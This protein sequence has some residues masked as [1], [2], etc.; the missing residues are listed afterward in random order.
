MFIVCFILGAW[1]IVSCVIMCLCAPTI[2]YA[3]TVC[4]GYDRYFAYMRCFFFAFIGRRRCRRRHR[5]TFK[6]RSKGI[7]FTFILCQVTIFIFILFFAGPLRTSIIHSEPY[8]HTHTHQRAVHT[9]VLWDC[10]RRCEIENKMWLWAGL[11]SLS[12]QF[13][14]AIES[15]EHAHF[16][17]VSLSLCVCLCVCALAHFFSIL[18]G[19]E[20]CVRWLWFF[21]CLPVSLWLQSEWTMNSVRNRK[22]MHY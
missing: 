15:C 12:W 3:C 9:V 6:S 7:F 4:G 14:R 10:K 18:M 20:K 19:M 8:T 22:K 2:F 11:H 21:V 5:I 13:L 1:I 16:R 17:D